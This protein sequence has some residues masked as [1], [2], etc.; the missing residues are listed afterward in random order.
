MIRQLTQVG[1]SYSIEW[2]ENFTS[3]CCPKVSGDPVQ[4]QTLTNQTYE[5]DRFE[6]RVRF[7]K[8]I[9]TLFTHFLNHSPGEIEQ[10]IDFS[11]Q[12]VGNFID[13]DCSC[14]LILNDDSERVDRS[15]IWC[16]PNTM[17][18]IQKVPDFSLDQVPWL[19]RNLRQQESVL[20]E[21]VDVLSG[22]ATAEKRLLSRHGIQAF[23]A[24]PMIYR[25][26]LIG[27]LGFEFLDTRRPLHRDN[28][29]LLKIVGEMFVNAFERN[30]S[31]KALR[32]SE[33]RFRQVITSISDH[34]YFYKVNPNEGH[35]NLYL[36]PNIAELTGYPYNNFTNDWSFWPKKV[37]HPEDRAT[38]DI[39]AQKLVKGEDS[40][41]IYRLEKAN[42]EIIWVR[43]SA[44]TEQSGDT[45]F[46][47]GVV[48]DINERKIAED[49]LAEE[50]AL[51]AQRVEKRTA[52]LSLANA[53]LARANR[54]KDEFLAAMSHELRTPLN[55]VLGMSEALQEQVY[56]EMNEKQLNALS[57][58]EES[59]RHL[60]SLINDILDLARI[61]AGK[62]EP[63]LGPVHIDMVC[64]IS[65][66]FV[67]KDA[68]DK[69]LKLQVE[70]EP[71][72][73]I[74]ADERRLKQVL[75]NLLSN[76]VKFTPKGGQIGLEAKV[77]PEKQ[78]VD[79]VVWDTGIGIA[80]EDMKKLFQPFVQVDSRLSRQ[81]EGTGLGLS[82]V[83]KMVEIQRGS[84]TVESKIGE[85]TRFTV[86]LPYEDK[87]PQRPSPEDE[88][89]KPD[90]MITI[91]PND[92]RP[93]V[94]LAEDNEANIMTM[95]DYLQARD[96]ALIVAR[97]GAQVLERLREI[98]PAIILMDIQM[99]VMD[100][101]EAIR[102]VR[103]EKEW[104]GIPI[105]ALTALAMPG[106]RERCL[107]AGA[108]EY[109][110][111]PVSLRQLT[112]LIEKLIG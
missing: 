12:A 30:K 22:E 77:N 83:Y 27:M 73:V 46:V 8:L 29:P 40:E 104:Q 50:R 49:A 90:E 57:R 102:R 112:R 54:M 15:Y 67:E 58:I 70:A 97:N 36:S 81:Y 64:Q 59:G 28:L 37:I 62:L 52:D 98:R 9:A 17:G 63:Q 31:E 1:K 39:Q 5:N 76:A 13:A 66:H 3:R 79:F 105:I 96:F 14:I 61:E 19:L 94:L 106:D 74:Y 87:Q 42:G 103:S 92:T 60:L 78:S 56:G 10:G 20:I 21:N 69:R 45:I 24:I 4:E 18:L 26:T 23:S 109:L 91:P 99:P 55:A 25:G 101:L 32:Q 86:S 35:T 48:N 72:L 51:L 111:K 100:G 44:R 110:S 38:A 65:V 2:L 84:V 89:D 71:G 53:E 34:I 11:L 93:L 68:R 47:Y 75:V 82:L 107:D 41:T 7:E 108:D 16:K 33:E 80:E 88:V 43:D 85:G 95:S 6:E